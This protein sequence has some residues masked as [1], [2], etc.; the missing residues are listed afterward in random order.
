MDAKWDGFV[1]VLEAAFNGIFTCELL[2]KVLEQ[3]PPA[4]NPSTRTLNSD[5]LKS[6]DPQ[7]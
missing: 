3:R 6:D 2:I 4:S 1:F 7:L 5:D